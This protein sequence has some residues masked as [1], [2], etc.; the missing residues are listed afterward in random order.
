[1]IRHILS[2]LFIITTIAWIV[3]NKE[4]LIDHCESLT[5]SADV[6]EAF[7][8]GVE[9]DSLYEGYKP[10]FM[11]VEKINEQELSVQARIGY[12]LSRGF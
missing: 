8:V 7:S 5:L 10:T 4:V 2:S 11:Q 6:T 3:C 12:L 9:K 1:M